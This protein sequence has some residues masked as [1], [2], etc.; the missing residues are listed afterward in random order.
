M[1][2]DERASVNDPPARVARGPGRGPDGRS[3]DVESGAGTPPWLAATL[4]Y[5]SNCGGELQLGS[6]EGEERQRLACASCGHIAYVNP[7][8]VVTCLPVT[9][10]GD[11]VLIRRGLEPG[12]GLWAQPGGFLEVDETVT[13]GVVR[14]TLEET[15]LIVVPGEI[16]GL[17]SRLEAAVVVLAVEARIVGGAIQA[18]PEATEVRSFGPEAIPWPEIAFK[19]TY[20]A[21][22]DWLALRHPG[23]QPPARSRDLG[24]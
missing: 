14:E 10:A 7:R 4:N 6:V 15:G 2:L 24:R 18:T 1:T 23:L 3:T 22:V 19:T 13:E 5:C 8:L 20:W 9:E 11:L 17:Y 21:I 12:K 16:V